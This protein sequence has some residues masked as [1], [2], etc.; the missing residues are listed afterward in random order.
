MDLQI[1]NTE[2]WLEME[3]MHFKVQHSNMHPAEPGSQSD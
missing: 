2:C 1:L 3:S